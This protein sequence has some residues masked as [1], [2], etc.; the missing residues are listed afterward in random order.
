MII[1]PVEKLEACGQSIL[2]ARIETKAT[3][4]P[5]PK[6]LWFSFPENFEPFLLLRGDA[7][8][9]GTLIAA[10]ALCEDIE[11]RSPVSPRL[12]SNLLEYQRL[13][14]LWF[15]G[16]LT[17]IQI[18][19][20]GLEILSPRAGYGSTAALFSGGVDSSFVL[21]A[22]LAPQQPIVEF[23]VKY[24]LFVHGA[25]IPLG[26]PERFSQLAELSKKSLHPVGVDLVPC[27][28][29]VRSFT[30]GL[31][32]WIYS[33]GAGLI[34]TGLALSGLLKRLYVASS[35]NYRSLVPWGS[36]PLLDHWLSTE[37][38]EIV[39]YGAGYRKPEKIKIVANWEPAFSYL[40]VCPTTEPIEAVNCERCAKC[41][42][43]KAMLEMEDAL[44]KFDTFPHPLTPGDYIRWAIIGSPL[45]NIPDLFL[46][47]S[48]VDRKWKVI[49]F[50]LLVLLGKTIRYWLDRWTPS[51]LR[52]YL[53]DR[54]FPLEKNPFFAPNLPE[55]Q[56]RISN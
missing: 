54:Y 12:V 53:R 14:G 30:E 55:D 45:T 13:L 41:L 34:S 25:D 56:N 2:S 15:P 9:V 51:W 3:S 19:Y 33:H 42:E 24:A 29:N 4:F 26:L 39:H 35:F 47:Q 1:H 16:Q 38:L 17:P 6:T 7:F 37:T 32:K 10:M 22:N 20:R 21:S 23:Q 48:L 43:I 40:R 52:K 46:R 49:P 27:A 11:I 8:L 36:S 28:T 44:G 31:F 5:F 18:G 50:A